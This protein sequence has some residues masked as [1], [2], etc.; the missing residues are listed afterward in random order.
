MVVK[1]DLW[2]EY[3][4]SVKK[5]KRTNRGYIIEMICVCFID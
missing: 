4:L 1:N 5:N 3:V 2:N